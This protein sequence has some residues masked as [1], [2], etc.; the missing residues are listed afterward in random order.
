[1]GTINECGTPVAPHDGTATATYTYNDADGTITINGVGAYLGLAKVVNGP[2][3]L[4]PEQ[5]ANSI[6][7]MAT[8]SENGNILDLDIEIITADGSQG[9]WS[10]KLER[11]MQ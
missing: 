3:L 2:E 7:Y 4:S 5:A 10:F 11:Q 8:L 9:F 1:Q 6:T